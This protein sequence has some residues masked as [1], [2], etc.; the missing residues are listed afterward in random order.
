[1]SMFTA[2]S[3]RGALA[4]IASLAI[5]GSVAGCSGNTA[6]QGSAEA[7]GSSSTQ[8][9]EKVELQIFAANSLEKALPEVQAL[10]TEQT[11][12]TFADTQ[13]KAS[14]DL[15][16][17]MRA[18]AQVDALI[19]ASKGTMDDAVEADLVDESTRE[20]MFVNDLVIVK[21]EGSDLAISSIEDVASLDGKI[22]IGDAA[23]VP[24]GKYA[25]QALASVS[26]YTNA[27]GT[28]GEYAASIADKVAL[29]DKVGT[30]AKYVSTGDCV[31]GFVYS[32][33]IFRYDGIEEAF[34]CPEDS[35]KPIVYPGAVSATSENAEEA[36]KFL[37]F[38]LTNK[39]AQKIWAKYGFELSE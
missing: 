20:D 38:C 39:D 5:A 25:N 6:A 32:S 15:V 36:A 33:D 22:A 27:E 10:Y 14:G 1:M 16:E 34:V 35:H 19:T 7:A 17:Q 3:R 26:L 4:L 11:G 23:T 18:G 31:A 9:A 12:V 8:S 30:A 21:A 24:A 37:E 2:M 13:F 28:D 29:A